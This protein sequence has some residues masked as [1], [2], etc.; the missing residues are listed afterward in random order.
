MAA[1]TKMYGDTIAV[2]QLYYARAAAELGSFSRAAAALGVT[3]PA[4][5]HGI[6]ALERTLGGPLFHRSTTGVTPSPLALRVLPHVHTVLADLDALLAEARAVAGQDAEPLRMGVSPLIHPDLVARAFQAARH[7]APAALILKE[8]NL[9][10]LQAAMLSRELDLILV[11]AVTEA[12][13]CHRRRIDAEPLHY[14][15]GAGTGFDPGHPSTPD[16]QPIE[17]TEL[18]GRPLIMV[19]DACGLT[20]FTRTLFTT[21]GTRL[22]AYPGEADNYRSLEDWANL[23]LGGALMPASRFRHNEHTRPVHDRGRPVIITYE[24]LWLTNTTRAEAIETLLENVLN[25]S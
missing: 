24:A 20:T 17:L 12:E 5:S 18:S 23:G 22:R 9:A 7:H 19:G 1:I 13:G 25:P 4:L 14:L 15:P 16:R 2:T 11:P 10:A 21:T 6:A 3:Q 8:D